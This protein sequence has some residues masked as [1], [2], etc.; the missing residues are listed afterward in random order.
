MA[1]WLQS[2]WKGLNGF[3]LRFSTVLVVHSLHVCWKF[4]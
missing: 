2:T 4:S 1:V 3:M